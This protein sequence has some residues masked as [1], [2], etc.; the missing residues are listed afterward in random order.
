[1]KV[2]REKKRRIKFIDGIDE[3]MERTILNECETNYYYNDWCGR[4]SLVGKEKEGELYLIYP[5]H[6]TTLTDIK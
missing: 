1:M 2:V 5:R 3:G 4:Y 6:K